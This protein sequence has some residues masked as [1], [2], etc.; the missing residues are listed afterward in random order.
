MTDQPTNRRP[1][2]GRARKRAIR[3]HAAQAGVAYSVAARLLDGGT[4]E[5]SASTG[6]TV[7]PA[8]PDEH[9]QWLIKMWQARPFDLRVRD[10]RQAAQL[11]LGRAEQLGLRFPAGRGEPGSGVDRLYHGDSR[12]AA[13]AML[14]AVV[15]HERPELCPSAEELAWLA[16]LGEETGLDLAFAPIDRTA[17]RLLDQER[18]RLWPRV[19]AALRHCAGSPDRPVR[20]AGQAIAAE[21]RS[22][23]LA[24]SVDGA[25]Q[26]LDALLVAGDGGHAPGTAVRLR[27]QPWRGR[28]ATIVG[29]YWDDAGGPVRYDVVLS[30]VVHSDVVHNGHPI[31]AEPTDLTL[32]DPTP[33]RV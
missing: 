13:I 17:R 1:A 2:A 14:Y 30:D 21:L 20:D 4:I 22:L 12:A 26:T 19:E 29:A 24:S 31:V 11:P 28:V 23:A 6:A 8:S 15:V 10:A 32:V 3:A 7:Y 5:P 9:R 25:R 33:A 18:W 27:V 16:D